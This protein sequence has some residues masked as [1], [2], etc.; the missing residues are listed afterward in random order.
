MPTKIKNVLTYFFEKRISVIVLF[1]GNVIVF[2]YA[3]PE[4]HYSI[5][6]FFHLMV[7][8]LLNIDFKNIIIQV[9]SIVFLSLIYLGLDYLTLRILW[10]RII[11][12]MLFLYMTIATAYLPI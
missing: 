8:D 9:M 5:N 1:I 11:A 7:S 2:R 4:R 6:S 10:L 12:F 3:V